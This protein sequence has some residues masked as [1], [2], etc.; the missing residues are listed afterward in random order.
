MTYA[1]PLLLTTA[2]LFG[3]VWSLA[4]DGLADTLG[5]LLAAAPLGTIVW[6]LFR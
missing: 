6:R 2:V 1:R 3:L 4:A 5:S